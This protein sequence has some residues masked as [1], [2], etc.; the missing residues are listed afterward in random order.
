VIPEWV[1][2]AER[3]DLT[4]VFLPLAVAVLIAGLLVA[5]QS[6]AAWFDDRNP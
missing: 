3:T 4:A 1:E 2:L 6:I 5:A